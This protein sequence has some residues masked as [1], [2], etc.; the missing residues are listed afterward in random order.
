MLSE[1]DIKFSYVN[2]KITKTRGSDVVAKHCSSQVTNQNRIRD[3]FMGTQQFL[4]LNYDA[5]SSDVVTKLPNSRHFNHNLLSQFI[6]FLWYVSVRRIIRIFFVSKKYS[7]TTSPQNYGLPTPSL[8]QVSV[9]T[10]SSMMLQ[11]KN[12]ECRRLWILVQ[13]SGLT[14][15]IVV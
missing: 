3:I 15:D 14:V 12:V 8:C 10:Y 6:I 5:I 4:K 13:F 9:Q 11:Y 2:S 1:V 7:L